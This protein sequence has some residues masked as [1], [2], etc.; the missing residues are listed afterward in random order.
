MSKESFL[1]VGAAAKILN[2]SAQSVRKYEGRGLLRAVR[3]SGGLR[4]FR[5]GDV[6]KFAEEKRVKSTATRREE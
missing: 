4:L 6:R 3:A 2:L 5:E 1:T